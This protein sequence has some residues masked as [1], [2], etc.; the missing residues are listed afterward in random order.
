MD[1]H[2]TFAKFPS[3]PTPKLFFRLCVRLL[4][5]LPVFANWAAAAEQTSPF[6][7]QATQLEAGATRL[8]ELDFYPCELQGQG[9]HKHRLA[10]CAWLSVPEDPNQPRGASRQVFVARLAARNAQSLPDPLVAIAGGPGQAASQAFAHLDRMLWSLAGRRD[11]Y[12]LDAR[13]TGR[14]DPQDCELDTDQ[15]RLFEF[16]PVKVREQAQSCL[17]QLERSPQFDTTSV[18]VR[19]LEALREALGLGQWNLLGVSYGTR[20]VQHYMRRY[21]TA[22]RAAVLDGVVPPQEALGPDIALHS[23]EALDGFLTDCAQRKACRLAYPN[24]EQKLEQL[25]TDLAAQPRAV[26]YEDLHNGELKSIQFGASDLAVLVRLA[27]YNT[28]HL[29]TLPPMLKAAYQDRN[30]SALARMSQSLAEQMDQAMAFAMHNSVL[31]TE[32]VPFYQVSAARMAAI[33]DT[34]LGR[35]LLEGLQAICEV[36]PTGYRDE[37][38]NQ[39]LSTDIPSLLLSG[40][41]DPITPPDYAEHAAQGLSNSRHLVAKGQGHGVFPIGCMPEVIAQFIETANPRGLNTDCLKPLKA[42]PVFL[43]MNGPGP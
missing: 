10:Q 24:L 2:K 16:D 6:N 39:P 22:V 28:E 40:E 29:S 9:S 43:N 17:K 12:L 41:R 32:D 18:A 26:E 7:P 5:C 33:E 27:L 21:P 1:M 14:S 35:D 30:Y 23:Q 38:L 42:A 4:F 31:C 8:G 36:W 19:D 15:A 3:A 37:D 25:F 34:Y 20:V 11:I 13:G